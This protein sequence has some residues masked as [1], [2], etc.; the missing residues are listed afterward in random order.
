M[1]ATGRQCAGGEFVAGTA[2]GGGTARGENAAEAVLKPDGDPADDT[3]RQAGRGPAQRL[4]EPA[5]RG[6]ADLTG[7]LRLLDDG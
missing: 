5:G 4:D 7:G 3:G 1:S 6:V 2:R